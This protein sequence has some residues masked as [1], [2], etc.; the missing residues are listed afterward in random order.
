MLFRSTVPVGRNLKFSPQN[1]VVDALIGGWK[2]AGTFV[3]YTGQPFNITGTGS[4]LQCTG[5]SQTAFQIGSVRKLGGHGPQDPY[6]D[7]MSFR[8][9]QWYFNA[10]SP[11][12]IPGTVGR[13]ALYGP[14]YWRLNPAIYKN[15]QVKVFKG[16][17]P[18]N[19]EFRAESNNITNSPVWSTPNGGSASL[20][21]IPRGSP[22]E[23]AL[24]TSVANP[25]GNFMSMTGAST[26][27]EFRFGL[28]VSF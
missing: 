5:C 19:M 4:S 11:N 3:A 7:P 22:N 27:R 15:F 13:N 16:R 25:T 14:G 26:G 6:Y 17:E 23:G 10:A 24:D 1:K 8:D 18:I 28:R 9:P 2:V 12:Y 21:L 20:R